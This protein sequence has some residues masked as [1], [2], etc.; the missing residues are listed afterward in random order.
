MDASSF[1]GSARLKDHSICR[2]K[3]STTSAQALLARIADG[4][5]SDG[6][7]SDDEFEESDE[8]GLKFLGILTSGTIRANRLLGCEL[9]SEKALKKE[10]RGSSDF[11][12]AEEGDVVIVRWYD[13]GPVNMVSTIVGLVLIRA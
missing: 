13:N 8:I 2:Q 3:A 7:F 6:D 9:K 4:N 11:K 12:I 10:G 1:Y 5:I